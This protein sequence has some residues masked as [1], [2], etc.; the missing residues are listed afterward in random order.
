MAKNTSEV[1]KL[2]IIIP[3]YNVEKYI[4]RCLRSAAV[5]D[6]P[7][8]EYEII[9]INDGSTDGSSKIIEAISKEFTNISLHNQEN[10]GLGGA[11]NKGITLAKG[12]Y[13]WFIDSD[14][15][16]EQNS[17]N[18]V[19]S[20]SFEND[21]DILSFEFG[22]TNENGDAINWIEFSLDYMGKPSLTG[23]AFYSVN[24]KHNYI[25]L[26]LF[27]RSLFLNNNLFFEE[28]INMQDSEIMPRIM[29]HVK[30]IMHAPQVVYYYV[31]RE[32]SF[33]NNKSK[34][35]RTRYYF[36]II[37]VA[38]L[39]NSFKKT[40]PIT[41]L[42]TITLN[43][44]LSEI[45]RILFLQ[46]IYND[47]D[48]KTLNELLSKLKENHLYPFK[49]IKHEEVTK[50]IIYNTLRFFINKFPIHSRT[51]YLRINR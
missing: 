8:N 44:K 34:K 49:F 3:V 25:W 9:V 51:L 32:D 22:C 40:L 14:D 48:D 43:K 45:N 46:F 2:S 42:M 27:K 6:L 16:I 38:N 26:Y 5:Q 18:H 35:V 50:V 17:L 30:K 7:P 21:V 36:S 37:T 15:F 24:Y 13:I 23:E 4:E 11:R 31:N 20:K 39:L 1:M 33:I 10:T 12:T 47:F 28:R 19:V 29:W 41:S